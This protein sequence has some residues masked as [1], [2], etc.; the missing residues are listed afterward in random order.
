MSW[1]EIPP[2]TRDFIFP[3]RFR[4]VLEP[5]QPS[6][7]WVHVGLSL[8]VKSSCEAVHLTFYLAFGISHIIMLH[9]L[10]LVTGI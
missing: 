1:V 3:K 8:G 2:G 4:M 6:L 7:Q 5:A 9:V 10:D